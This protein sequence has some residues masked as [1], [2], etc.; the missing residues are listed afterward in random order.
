MVFWDSRNLFSILALSKDFIGSVLIKPER[1][2]NTKI[3]ELAIV[4]K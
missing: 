2:T 1:E 3:R 4:E